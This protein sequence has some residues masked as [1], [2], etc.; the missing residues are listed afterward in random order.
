MAGLLLRGRCGGVSWH[1]RRRVLD[2][3]GA[4]YGRNALIIR[5]HMRN[6]RRIGDRRRQTPLSEGDIRDGLAGPTLL[7]DSETPRERIS[8]LGQPEFPLRAEI[9]EGQVH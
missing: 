5:R 1:L 4:L 9:L 7:Y 6:E 3:G 8:L 2:G